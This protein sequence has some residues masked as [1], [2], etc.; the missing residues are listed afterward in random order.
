MR[1]YG[2][3]ANSRRETAQ[4]PTTRAIRV[5]LVS[6]LTSVVLI[7]LVALARQGPERRQLLETV[8]TSPAADVSGSDLAGATTVFPPNEDDVASFQPQVKREK[9]QGL[10]VVL[11]FHI[12]LIINMLDSV[13]FT[14]VTICVRRLRQF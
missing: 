10:F 12:G 11:S 2:S 14:H 5:A 4:T 7:T 3:F 13:T 1:S 6:L 9:Y 8:T